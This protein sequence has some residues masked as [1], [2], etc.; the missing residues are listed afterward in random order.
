MKR[1]CIIYIFS[2]N[3]PLQIKSTDKKPAS[4]ENK[5][6]TIKQ[7]QRVFESANPSYQYSSN[8][9]FEVTC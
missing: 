8:L 3:E 9:R 1:D 5:T 6:A 4:N 2:N 7:N